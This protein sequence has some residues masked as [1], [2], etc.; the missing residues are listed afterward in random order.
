M[1]EEL[2]TEIIEN[3]DKKEKKISK[4]WNKAKNSVNST[5]LENKIKNAYED[6]HTKFNVYQYEDLLPTI[7]FGEIVDNSL[8]Y[9]G[10]KVINEYSVVVD[11]ETKKAY[12]ALDSVPAKINVCVDNETYTRD[13]VNLKLDANVTEVKVIK[14]SKSYYLYKGK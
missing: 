4:L 2:K 13:G 12:Y 14:A 5:L 9:F 1:S 7:V 11:S 3:S 8:V 10:N 6:K